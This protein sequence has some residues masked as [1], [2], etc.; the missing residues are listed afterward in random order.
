MPFAQRFV[1]SPKRTAITAA[2]IG[3]VSLPAAATNGMNLEAYGAKAGGM[4]GASF[5]YDNG[6]SA[7]MNNPAT[8]GLR[9]EG[10]NLGLGWTLLAPDVN[11]SMNH[12]VAGPLTAKSG[13]DA[14]HM[15]SVSFI[16]KT[17]KITYGVGML[18]QG[19]MGTEYGTNSSCPMARVCPCAPRW[20]LAAS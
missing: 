1:S 3:L 17:G 2:L 19:G 13:G 18:A 4:G 14:Y 16:R 10:S 20:V 7:L 6:N 5:A 9:A 15:P 8:L 12:P 11:T